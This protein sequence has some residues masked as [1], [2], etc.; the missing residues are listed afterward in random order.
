MTQII[1]PGGGGGGIVAGQII[2]YHTLLTGTVTS[3]GTSFSGGADLLASAM[4][5]TADG[6]SDYGVY[7]VATAMGDATSGDGCQLRLNLDGADQGVMAQSLS[8]ITSSLNTLTAVGIIPAAVATVGV[9]TI[10]V[11]LN[12][13]TG[14]TASVVGGPGGAGSNAPLAVFVVKM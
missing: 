8:A 13:I 10:N 12:A 7:C 1:V 14:G 9:H 4:N 6:T 3:S 2:A 5:F 11:R